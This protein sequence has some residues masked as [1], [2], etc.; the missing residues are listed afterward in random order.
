MCDSGSLIA[1]ELL[2]KD[3]KGH[4][5]NS[6]TKIKWKTGMGEFASEGTVKINKAAFPSLATQH[7]LDIEFNLLP[8]KENHS[9]RAMIGMRDLK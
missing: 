5:K 7:Q 1:P 2:D 9:H 4:A 3:F 8:R 6:T